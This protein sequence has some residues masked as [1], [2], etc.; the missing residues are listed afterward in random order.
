M[1]AVMKNNAKKIIFSLLT[2]LFLSAGLV[3]A[4]ESFNQHSS[5]LAEDGIQTVSAESQPPATLCC[6]DKGP[7]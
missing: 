7:K 3:R 4:A 1:V 2:S 5:L 6:T